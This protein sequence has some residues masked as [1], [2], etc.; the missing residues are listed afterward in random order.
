MRVLVWTN[1]EAQT[2]NTREVNLKSRVK[3]SL[4]DVRPETIEFYDN[5]DA[6]FM[7]KQILEDVVRED[8]PCNA[9]AQYKDI[10]LPSNFLQECV[11]VAP[12]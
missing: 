2:L 7:L 9:V 3:Q 6:F 5:L 11:P 12:L 8:M 1:S 4:I 10:K